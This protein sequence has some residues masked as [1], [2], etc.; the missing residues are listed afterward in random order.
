MAGTASGDIEGARTVTATCT[1]GKVAVGGGFQTSSVSNANEIVITASYPS[2]STAWTVSG[3]SDN[4][5]G[6]ASF[7]L[8][9]HVI[10]ATAP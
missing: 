3:T 1:A 6:D 4:N 5:N 7:A 2:S 10:C 8:Q 9:S